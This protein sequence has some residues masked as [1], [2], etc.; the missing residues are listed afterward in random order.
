[1]FQQPPREDRRLTWLLVAAWAWFILDLGPRLRPAV[2]RM[3]EAGLQSW[4]IW[5]TIALTALAALVALWQAASNPRL[6][7]FRHA[8]ALIAVVLAYAYL[9]LYRIERPAEALHF[10]EYGGLG[11][12]AFR[13]F[14][15]R[16]RDVA[17]YAAAVLLCGLVGTADECLQ[18]LY[19]DRVWDLHDWGWDVLS[20]ALAQVAVG[21]GLAPPFIGRSPAAPSRRLVL[22]LA[23]CQ[24]VLLWLCLSNT[25]GRTQGWARRAPGLSFILTHRYPM[26]EYGWRHEVPGI[27]AFVSRFTLAEL[28]ALNGSRGAEAGAVLRAYRRIGVK[29][30]ARAFTPYTDAYLAEALGHADERESYLGAAPKYRGD[31]DLYR[32]HL[33]KACGE[34]E[35][36]ERHFSNLM[37]SAGQRLPAGLVETLRAGKGGE[38]FES[39]VNEDVITAVR[40]WQVHALFALGLALLATAGARYARFSGGRR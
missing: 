33:A 21:L 13:A 24:L 9:C 7:R 10:L 17:A 11:V 18:W 8:G 25:P 29:E 32:R 6:R 38:P 27:G 22:R 1:V 36:L 40:E 28:E 4:L 15:H 12:L 31:P 2:L 30:F 19:P 3:V 20:A 14:S 26:V 5:A 34:N 35:V 39:D 37:S 23:G 16:V